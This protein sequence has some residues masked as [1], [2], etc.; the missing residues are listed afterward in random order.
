ML[1]G[2]APAHTRRRPGY[3]RWRRTSHMS[4]V[5]LFSMCG[6]PACCGRARAAPSG[7]E[8]EGNDS[9]DLFDDTPTEPLTDRTEE[10]ETRRTRRAYRALHTDEDEDARAP[11]PSA[12]GPAEPR[13]GRPAADKGRPTCSEQE[14][15]AASRA[16][17][18]QS[19]MPL[20]QASRP[21][22][23]RIRSVRCKVTK[24]VRLH[25]HEK[26]VSRLKL[27]PWA[28]AC[29]PCALSSVVRPTS[30]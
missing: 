30:L 19:G 7:G 15:P 23:Q 28:R 25:P 18:T 26:P 17:S 8:G 20:T 14:Q 10:G 24:T 1:L 3:D 21:A 4:L 29:W 6:A 12:S 11:P 2:P 22:V 13:V 16:A 27:L 9:P 5:Q